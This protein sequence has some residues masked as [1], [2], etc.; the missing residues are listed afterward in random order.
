MESAGRRAQEGYVEDVARAIA[1]VLRRHPVVSATVLGASI[2]GLL[3]SPRFTPSFV[4]AWTVS[5]AFVAGAALGVRAPAAFGTPARARVAAALLAVA[6]GALAGYFID[7]FDTYAPR[8]WIARLAAAGFAFFFGFGLRDALTTACAAGLAAVTLVPNVVTGALG[9][10][11]GPHGT[12]VYA[13]WVA[14][15]A[16]LIVAR[17]GRW[18]LAL[19]FAIAAVCWRDWAL[20]WGA[21]VRVLPAEFIPM[22][23]LTFAVTS[24]S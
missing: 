14:V 4:L 20:M 13:G 9:M 6:G 11:R 15:V 19:P 21:N 1:G 24:A 3:I 7:A 5:A 12:A 10:Q 18:M 16:M 8:V 2:A 22:I 23:A 17:R